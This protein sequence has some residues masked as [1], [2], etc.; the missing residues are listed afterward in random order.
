M[1]LARSTFLCLALSFAA[2]AFAD[3]PSSM[4]APYDPT[5][6]WEVDYESGVL[7]K[8]TGDATPLSYTFEPQ[9]LTVQSPINGDARSLWGGDL[10]IPQ[11]VQPPR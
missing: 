5:Q 11:P 7:W 1:N 2:A 4:V 8:F 9:I 6:H 3:S 10:L